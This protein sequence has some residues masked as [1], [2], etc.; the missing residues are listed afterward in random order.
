MRFTYDWLRRFL[1][2]D[3]N[4]SQIAEK[5]TSIGLEVESLEDP[6]VMFQKFSLAQ[7]ES[8]E[9]HPGADRLKKCIVKTPDGQLHHVVCG[10][11]NARA[12]LKTI[13]A[14]PGARIPRD[15][16]I[17]K[18]SKI[19]GEVSEGMM[20]SKS[21]LGISED[22]DGIID[23][24]DDFD[25]SSQSVGNVLGYGGGIFD[26]S[27]TPNR[28]DCFSVKGI[29]RDLAVAGAGTF[30]EPKNI[31][32]PSSFDF[33]IKITEGCG[34]ESYM[35]FGAFRVIRGVKNGESP[36]WLKELLR[37]AGMNS[38]S[39]LVDLSNLWL[40]DRGRPL[41]IYDLN[42]IG[43]DIAMRF[44]YNKEKFVD[45]KGNER[46]LQG[47]MV[48]TVDA[49][50]DEALCLMGIIG[51]ERAACDENTS[52][53]LIES[54]YF[55][56]ISIAKVGN[57]LNIT[58]DS[59]TRFERGIDYESCIP[60]L[61]NI[62]AA[63]LDLC[64]GKA[65]SIYTIGNIPTNNLSPI[66]LRKN[67]MNKVAGFAVDFK[68]AEKI[69]LDLGLKVVSSS[70]TS[71]SKESDSITFTTPSWRHDLKIEEDLIEEVL[72]IIGYDAVTSLELKKRPKGKDKILNNF[73]ESAFIKKILAARGLSE[74]ITYSFIKKEYA[75]AFREDKKLLLL[76]N[77]IS[78]DMSVMRTSLLPGLIAVAARNLNYG[79][80]HVEL[81][82][83]GDVFFDDCRQETNIA[84]LRIG[85]NHE[86]SW[87]DKNRE[88]D[89]FDAKTDLLTVLEH[90][91]VSEKDITVRTAKS[92][93][94]SYYHPFRSGSVFADKKFVGYFGEVHPKIAKLFDINGR[95]VCF[96]VFLNNLKNSRNKPP[97]NSKV[98]PTIDR[99]FSFVF[100]TEIPV[101][102]L[103]R[104]IYKLDPRVLKADIF[105]CFELSKKQ[106]AVGFTVTIGADDRTLTEEEAELVSA[107]I[108]E[109]IAKMGGEL[110]SK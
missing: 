5:L 69:L 108:V 107:K 97:Y 40:V 30:I 91:G 12:G 18:K 52:D 53:I 7:I 70:S 57:F 49:N 76:L 96:E 72:R 10:A 83:F 48:V 95:I 23:L 110:R 13:L 34:I 71:S 74:V 67:K 100:S 24:G 105:D 46:I 33:P 51:S 16:E 25:I 1:S 102:N 21:E 64:G 9:K 54:A 94:P 65:S 31:Q 86:R 11:P 99:D 44:A 15:G 78:E 19:R 104:E 41:H 90:Y 82:E 89:V 32:M 50:S 106:K 85:K 88:A 42:K 17:L 109:Y 26:I 55:D 4:A 59:R 38:I 43:T 98:F 81:M 36:S 84:G 8:A 79:N 3:L 80:T 61:E 87:L 39:A 58:S 35:P 77:P 14:L 22:S 29:A 101:G 2:T 6:A 60:E 56:P 75:E 47:D 92:D 37:I 20:C 93:I 66:T 28:G 27:V 103:V 45:L 73:R 63:I 68:R 62:T